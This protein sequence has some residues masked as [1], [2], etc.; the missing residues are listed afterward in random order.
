[1]VQVRLQGNCA[2]GHMLQA[3]DSRSNGD[4]KLRPQKQETA[5]FA[6]LLINVSS[7]ETVDTNKRTND[8][9]RLTEQPNSF[10]C[11][12]ECFP[13]QDILHHYFPP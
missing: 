10:H 11:S 3:A 8:P 1:M 4:G 13:S 7:Q 12:D 5:T 6:S 2:S 9:F